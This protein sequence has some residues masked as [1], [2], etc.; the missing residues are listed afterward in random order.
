[1]FFNDKYRFDF[2]IQILIF[3]TYL[4]SLTFSYN[5]CPNLSTF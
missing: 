4:L 3:Q 5:H 1:M 2:G